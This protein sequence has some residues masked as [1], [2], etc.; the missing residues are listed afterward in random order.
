MRQD[1]TSDSERAAT[2]R[3]QT[4][5]AAMQLL[6]FV[7]KESVYPTQM[8]VLSSLDHL[9]VPT[10]VVIRWGV[11]PQWTWSIWLEYR[12]LHADTIM[13]LVRFFSF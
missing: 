5:A 1:S 6:R 2:F 7:L 8:N 12:S 11:V 9:D 3:P 4:M 10:S 13:C